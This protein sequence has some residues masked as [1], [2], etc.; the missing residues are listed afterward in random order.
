MT[1]LSVDILEWRPRVSK[2]QLKE[3]G[4]CRSGR[5]AGRTRRDRNM[6]MVVF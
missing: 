4:N 3:E 5:E 1:C 2:K 6:S